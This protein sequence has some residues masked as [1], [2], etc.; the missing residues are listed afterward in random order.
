[1]KYVVLDT[2]CISTFIRINRVA[3]LLKILD[4]H[5]MVITEQVYRELKVSQIEALKNFRHPKILIKNANSSITES[6]PIHIGEASVI[7]FAKVNNALAVIDDRK[8][9]EIAQKEGV[10]FIG[11]ATLIKYG[12]EKGIIKKDEIDVLLEEI[13][14]V[15]KLYLNEEIKKWIKES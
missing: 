7:M 14:T 4:G 15:G 3:L 6:Y 10:E 5:E 8:A 13:T 12:M 2:S 1:M 11:S 9:R